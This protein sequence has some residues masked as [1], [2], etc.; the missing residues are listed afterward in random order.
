VVKDATEEPVKIGENIM[1]QSNIT[2]QRIFLVGEGLLFDEIVTQL[3]TF[4][5]DLLVSRAIYSDNLAFLN[6]IEGNRPDAM[7]ICDSGALDPARILALVSS[8]PL[9]TGLRT[10]VAR[11]DNNVLDVYARPICV[12]GKMYSRP[13]QIIARTGNDLINILRRK[14]NE[15][16]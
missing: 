3:L 6:I 7:L 2:Q 9:T 4:G 14:Y 13:R 5:T 12:E 1:L 15:Q 11:L 10:V 16:Q 8:H